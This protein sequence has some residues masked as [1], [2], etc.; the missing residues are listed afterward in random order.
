MKKLIFT[1]MT[2]LV[3]VFVLAPTALASYPIPGK[4][5]PSN[6]AES[7]VEQN[8]K[9]M[10]DTESY[11]ALAVTFILADLV[12]GLL[13]ITGV[14][15]VYFLV[16]SGL[17]YATSFGQQD[18]IDKAKKGIT[19]SIVGIFVI[20]LAYAIVRFV[21]KIVLT[22]DSSQFQD[23]GSGA[24]AEDAAAEAAHIIMSLIG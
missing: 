12:S 14:I 1:I 11:G 19:W 8:S 6:I 7:W 22:T 3:A 9:A 15:A 16:S 24:A 10:G 20:M 4:Y 21:I 17:Q 18:K 5:Q 13:G 23:A 2:F